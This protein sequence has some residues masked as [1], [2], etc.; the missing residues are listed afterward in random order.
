MKF[1]IDKI[2]KLSMLELE[3]EEKEYLEKEM[4]KII[5]WVSKLEELDIEGEEVVFLTNT[6]LRDDEPE[7][8]LLRKDILPFQNYDGI[9]F[10]VPKVVEK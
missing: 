2:L 9:F 1:D 6:P 8:T 10:I 5:D 4:E 3:E 7:Q